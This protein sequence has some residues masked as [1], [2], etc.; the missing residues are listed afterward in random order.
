MLLRIVTWGISSDGAALFM[1][2]DRHLPHIT[3]RSN[4]VGR[5]HIPVLF[6]DDSVLSNLT[7]IVSKI[8]STT[9]WGYRI[10]KARM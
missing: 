3:T 5:L 1:N 2:H 9:L 6:P 4:D 8:R 10:V 7:Q